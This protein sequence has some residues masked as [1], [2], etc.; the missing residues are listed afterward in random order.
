M[1][2]SIGRIALLAGAATLL[3]PVTASAQEVRDLDDASSDIQ[4]FEGEVGTAPVVFRYTIPAN[5]SLRIDVIP[6]EESE[7]DPMLTVTDVA[8]GEVL[9][10]DDDGGEGLASRARIYSEEGQQVEITVSPFGLFS[11]DS[12]SGPFRLE[13]RPVLSRPQDV[14]GVSYGSVLDGMLE[15]GA[16][17]LFTIEG[18]K[19]ALLEV[20]LVAGDDGLDPTLSLFEGRGANGDPVS[21]NDDG[22]DGVNSLLRYVFPESGT[23][24]IMAEPFGDSSGSYT[25]RVAPEREYMVQAPVQVLG[26]GDRAAGRLGEGYESGSIDP[27]E[28]TYEL[29]AEAIAAIRASNGE[30][31]FNMTTPLFEDE[32]F[33]SGVD[34]YLELGFETPLG[35]ASVMSDD[36]GGEGLNSRI[37]IDLSPISGGDWLE[38]L[39]LRASSIGSGGDFE[40]ELVEGMQEV[41][42]YEWEEEPVE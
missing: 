5:T 27:T 13:L 16:E 10:E 22:G 35:F 15:S 41:E 23:Y 20:A 1:T 7:L 28:I 34:S 37:A 18:E 4:I 31:T 11:E 33:P 29:T 24:T 2:L 21:T 17:H 3:A 8:S 9:A 38:R 25:L 12:S 39:R 6:T 36:D 14:R 26:L 30:V 40:V 32:N 19:G 42:Q